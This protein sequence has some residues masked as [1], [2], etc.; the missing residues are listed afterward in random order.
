MKILIATDSF[1]DC[2]SSIEVA[3][4]I[5]KGILSIDDK[6]DTVIVPL[7]DGGEGAIFTL[8]NL[9]NSFLKN[10]ASVTPIG[11]HITSKWLKLDD[12]TAFIELANSSGLELLKPEERNP[13]LTSTYGTGL[14]IKDAITHN[15]KHIFLSLGGSA[16]ND[17]GIG[18][19]SALGF[20]FLDKDQNTLRPIGENLIKINSISLPRPCL[21]NGIKF[22][23]VC[24]VNNPLLGSNGASHTYAKQKGASNT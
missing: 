18:I 20:I 15:I 4:N 3:K 24:D 22:T 1:K 2:L 7:S 14:Q 17:G 12:E 6:L 10:S 11:K 5:E 16:T 19:L 13:L 21:L 9:P 23:F 8:M